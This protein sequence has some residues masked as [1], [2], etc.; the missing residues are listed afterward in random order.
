MVQ[1]IEKL[2]ERHHVLKLGDLLSLSENQLA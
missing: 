1:T 2:K